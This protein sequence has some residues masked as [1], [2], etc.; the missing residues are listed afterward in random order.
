[1]DRERRCVSSKARC[2]TEDLWLTFPDHDILREITVSAGTRDDEGE[3]EAIAS[4]DRAGCVSTREG[5]EI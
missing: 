3:D 2:I 4:S 1:M 5:S